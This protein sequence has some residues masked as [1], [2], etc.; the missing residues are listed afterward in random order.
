MKQGKWA[1]AVSAVA[2]WVTCTVAMSWAGVA[3]GGV[4][5]SDSLLVFPQPQH[6]TCG[7]G[8]VAVAQTPSLSI[9]TL[10]GDLDHDANQIIE[11][12]FSRCVTVPIEQQ[13][14]VSPW[15]LS[16]HQQISV[17]LNNTIPAQDT[18]SEILVQMESHN[19]FPDLDIEV[20]E[21]Y[22]IHVS[23]KIYIVAANVW[24]TLRA[25][26][27]VA[28]LLEWNGT[29]FT[30]QHT[31]LVI[32]DWPR[33][34]W[35]GMMIDTSR[36]FLPISKIK[37]II[38]GIAAMKMNVLHIHLTDSQ[39]FPY[40]NPE[41]E[42][43]SEKGKFDDDAYFSH[44][45][46]ED[47]VSH[48]KSLGVIVIPEFDMP[49]HTAS[50]GLGY[51]GITADCWDYLLDAQTTYPENR[52]PLNPA[53]NLTF[54]IIDSLIKDSLSV[55]SSDYVH[56]GGDEVHT[57]CWDNSVER[58]SILYWMSQNGISDWD[59]LEEYMT[60][61]AQ[62]S[63]TKNSKMP[64]VWE[65]AF[66]HG[67][68]LPNTIVAAWR[69]NTTL[70]DAVK[71]GY[72]AIQLYGWYQDMQAPLCTTYG[73]PE[74][75]THWLWV[76][77]YVDMYNNDPV[78]GKNLTSADEA[79]VL[80]G[81]AA[82]WGESVDI[83]SWDQ[84]GLTRSPAVAERL[85]SASSVVDRNWLEVRTD[86]FRCLAVRRGISEAGPLYSEYCELPEEVNEEEIELL[87]GV[88]FLGLVCLVLI[89]VS[90][91]L[92]Y[93]LFRVTRATADEPLLSQKK[94]LTQ[95]ND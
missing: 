91:L 61:Y 76:W 5:G 83:L 50:W 23:D 65:E 71:A 86:R 29:A 21:T 41:Y 31:P 36:H 84:R 62:N 81:E 38:E 9:T 57:D 13:M 52:I 19:T 73:C 28:Q 2:V 68:V 85:W 82:T 44:D 30:V 49:G 59:E 37:Q 72:D 15:I 20:N 77:T 48:A 46:L 94:P 10:D 26:E 45:D 87:V 51:P 16:L 12:A 39:S 70:R 35:R 43:L 58:D 93:K 55:F 42:E 54:N 60:L 69:T 88:A 32:E 24:G 4:V 11:S 7:M 74:C 53:N 80:G 95:A 90:I 1:I 79:H 92:G 40:E 78:L 64:I 27:T 6:A 17:Q 25:F 47:L 63:V 22:S 3:A 75:S 89:V 8:A 67:S 14:K 66:Y 34:R 18:I 56:V 33:F